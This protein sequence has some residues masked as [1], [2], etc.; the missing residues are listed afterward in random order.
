[1]VVNGECMSIFKNLV[2]IVNRSAVQYEIIE[3]EDITTVEAG[4]KILQCEPSQAI[5]TLAFIVNERYVFFAIRGDKKLDFKKITALLGTSRKTMSRI[6]ADELENNLGYEAGGLSPL[7]VDP[8][9]AVYFDENILEIETI[10]CGIGLRNK[11]LKIKSTHL[12]SL[13]E[14][15]LADITQ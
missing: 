1:M 12:F 15:I 10:Y 4:L 8:S 14:A 13:S 2:E 5:K 9:I 11:T 7:H 3:H 6:A